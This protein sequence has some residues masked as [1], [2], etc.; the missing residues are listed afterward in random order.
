MT[1]ADNEDF[2]PRTS[3]V[4]ILDKTI[5]IFQ[6]GKPDTGI[7]DDKSA[8]A[9]AFPGAEG[10]GR[11]TTGGR[12]GVLYKVTNLDDYGLGETP[13][14]GSLRYGIEQIQ[15]P[16]TIVFDVDGT[17]ELKRGILF[18]WIIPI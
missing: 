14:E 18:W 7:G 1:I 12:G 13:I 4:R 11:F 6:Y 5:T 17:I 10:G 16:R 3:T 2:L 15:G 9:L 8:E